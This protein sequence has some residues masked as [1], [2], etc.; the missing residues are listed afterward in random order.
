MGGVPFNILNMFNDLNVFNELKK[1]GKKSSSYSHAIPFPPEWS[2]TAC[3]SRLVFATNPKGRKPNTA[4]QGKTNAAGIV[5]R[6]LPAPI[7][8]AKR[9]DA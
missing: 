3:F 7:R 5:R 2:E 9:R 4:Y 1:E 8:R 6:Y